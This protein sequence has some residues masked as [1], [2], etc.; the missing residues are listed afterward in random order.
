MAEEPL[1]SELKIPVADFEAVRASLRRERAVMVQTMAREINLLLDQHDARLRTA[2]SLLRLRQHGDRNILTLKG[3]ASYRGA[4]KV[5]PERETAFSDLPRM[6]EIFE[7]LG[8]SVFMR[9]EKDREEWCLEEFSV[10]LDHTPM[11]D[12]VE[13]EGPSDGL[14]RA[15]HLLGLDAAAAVRGSYVSLW[16]EYRALHPELDL[17]SDM[18]FAE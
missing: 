5:R 3:P 11:G 17:P 4:I 15:A 8:F 2:G 12:F 9:Y 13:V 7:Q 10:V 16:L 1:E 6:L 18:V 14:E